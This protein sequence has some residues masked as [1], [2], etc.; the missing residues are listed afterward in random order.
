MAI[1][2]NPIEALRKQFD[3]ED[4]AKSPVTA[5][6]VKAATELVKFGKV[7]V[8]LNAI[9]QRV[10][11]LISND[12]NERIKIMLETVA[13]QVLKHDK[14]IREIQESQTVERARAKVEQ[15]ARLV[16][17]GARRAS[18]TRSVERVKRL[19]IILSQSIVDPTP[20][21]EDEIEEMMRI[22]TEL[23]DEDVKY[24]RELVTVH[25]RFVA[26]NRHMERYTA[27]NEWERG[28]WGT[29][30]D[31]KIDSVFNKL[32]S[33]GLVSAIAPNNTLNISADIQTR[34]ALLPKGLRFANLISA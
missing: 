12:S 21:D 34:Y 24:L 4:S 2:D 14:E 26:E 13:D 30:V 8:P 29:R 15:V 19:G 5:G 16:I 20:V 28:P 22:A 31:P 10:A 6:I 23:A 33:Y 7:P 9:I 11:Q 17:D 3:L 32:E 25:G 18:V 27:Y 1:D